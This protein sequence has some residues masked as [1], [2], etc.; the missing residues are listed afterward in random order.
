M[1]KK[2]EMKTRFYFNIIA[3]V[4]IFIAGWACQQEEKWIKPNT[5]FGDLES[6]LE[7]ADDA[8]VLILRNVLNNGSDLSEIKTIDHRIGELKGLKTLIVYGPR[9]PSFPAAL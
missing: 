3:F 6:A 2:H 7:H 4:L 8:E 1:L 9:Q 5:H